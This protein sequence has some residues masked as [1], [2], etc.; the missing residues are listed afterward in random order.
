MRVLYVFY[1]HFRISTH[2]EDVQNGNGTIATASTSSGFQ[3]SLAPEHETLKSSHISANNVSEGRRVSGA[4]M[5][6]KL[7]NI[8]SEDI[9]MRSAGRNA[10]RTA[11]K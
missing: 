11:Q 8:S 9:E 4:Q 5:S 7:S 6:E 1:Y 3:I 10:Y 2:S